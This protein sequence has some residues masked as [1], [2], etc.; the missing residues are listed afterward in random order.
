MKKLLL[1][2]VIFILFFF[3]CTKL[4][5]TDTASET[6]LLSDTISV[7]ISR[8]AMEQE[9]PS[10]FSDDTHE[11]QVQ[12][13]VII[14]ETLEERRKQFDDM[15]ILDM[16]DFYIEIGYY[17]NV[18]NDNVRNTLLGYF[19]FFSRESIQWYSDTSGPRYFPYFYIVDDYNL[20]IEVFS[21]F[22]SAELVRNYYC[23]TRKYYIDI[24]KDQLIDYYLRIIWK[25]ETCFTTEFIRVNLSERQERE[26]GGFFFE[27]LRDA[28]MY[29]NSA[30]QGSESGIVLSGNMVRIID[31]HY[32]NL[33]DRTPVALRV[34][35]DNLSGWVDFDSVDF[36]YM[37]NVDYLEIIANDWSR[38]F[39]VIDEPETEIDYS[40]YY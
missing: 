6:D 28:P 16:I 8:T 7:M 26:R 10:E 3:G 13:S 19:N 32:Q 39:S 15:T 35:T 29:E 14:E 2:F 31:M 36:F 17:I 4:K 12:P 25:I 1:L 9:Q 38:T 5:N 24:S 11:E 33:S 40:I 20:R 23:S 30:M 34:E 21:Y 22:G 27:M 37:F 18:G